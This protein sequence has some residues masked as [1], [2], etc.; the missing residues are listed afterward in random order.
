MNSAGFDVRKES[1][2]GAAGGGVLLGRG[3][4]T[5]LIVGSIFVSTILSWKTL[6]AMEDELVGV[7]AW[8]GW[9]KLE[10]TGAIG[11]AGRARAG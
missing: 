9:G 2:T 3:A 10:I 6:C 4:E 8:G 11:E 7:A 1:I 5:A